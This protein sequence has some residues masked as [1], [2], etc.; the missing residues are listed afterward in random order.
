MWVKFLFFWLPLV[1]DVWIQLFHGESFAVPRRRLRRWSVRRT[2]GIWCPAGAINLTIDVSE[3]WPA[4]RRPFH[5]TTQE[6]GSPIEEGQRIWRFLVQQRGQA[7]HM[8][9][10]MQRDVEVELPVLPVLYSSCVCL[11]CKAQSG[12]CHVA[13]RRW[14]QLL[15][16]ESV[17]AAGADFAAEGPRLLAASLVGPLYPASAVAAC[18]Y[19]LLFQYYSSFPHYHFSPTSYWPPAS[20]L[21][22]D[23]VALREIV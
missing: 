6:F 13:V 10:M 11:A 16:E 1:W 20:W 19:A 3:L 14:Q 12:C 22:R 9:E 2:G 4:Q 17:A 5:R 21:E 23:L 7:F 15:P 8:A 18:A